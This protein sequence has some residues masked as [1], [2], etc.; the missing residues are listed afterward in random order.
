[1]LLF[2]AAGESG[3]LFGVLA[4]WNAARS[5]RRSSRKFFLGAVLGTMELEDGRMSGS[6]F[7]GKLLK[8]P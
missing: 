4:M 3:I 6:L 8:L 5:S 1:M 2:T 7:G